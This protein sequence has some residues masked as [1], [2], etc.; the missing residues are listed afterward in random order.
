LFS[1]RVTGRQSSADLQAGYLTSV[2]QQLGQPGRRLGPGQ[3]YCSP[4]ERRPC[5]SGFQT[6]AGTALTDRTVSVDDDVPQA[7]GDVLSQPDDLAVDH[8]ARPD[9]RTDSGNNEP[10]DTSTRA[11]PV[12]GKRSPVA[13]GVEADWQVDRYGDI[14]G[15]AG[16]VQRWQVGGQEDATAAAVHVPRH[17]DAYC[18]GMK[19][20]CLCAF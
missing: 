1:R 20:F 7:P 18:F 3:F 2:S 16:S 6:P 17:D 12:L 10:R 5:R 11:E 4:L 9:A 8:H 14:S 15:Q 19:T 13:V